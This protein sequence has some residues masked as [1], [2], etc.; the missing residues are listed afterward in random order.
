MHTG[1][2]NLLFTPLSCRMDV[3]FLPRNVLTRPKNFPL[4]AIFFFL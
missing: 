1:D 4:S 3:D 2:R